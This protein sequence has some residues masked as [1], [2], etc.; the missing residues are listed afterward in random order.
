MPF[1]RSTG[2]Q[3]S[4]IGYTPDFVAYTDTA[5]RPIH[6]YTQWAT[7]NKEVGSRCVRTEQVTTEVT[8]SLEDLRQCRTFAC[9]A[10]VS[11]DNCRHM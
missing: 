11:D 4:L 6:R 5:N 8:M 3:T 9:R 2:T 1:S 7:Q 10:C